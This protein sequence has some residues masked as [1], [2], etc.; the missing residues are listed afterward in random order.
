MNPSFNSFVCA[1]LQ[2]EIVIVNELLWDGY[3]RYI[4]SE[5][6]IVVPVGLNGRNTFGDSGVVDGDDDE[7]LSVL[8]RCGGFAIEGCKAPFMFT[9]ELT[10]YPNVGAIVGSSYMDKGALRVVGLKVKIALI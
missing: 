4:S 2:V 9:E 5:A 1:V 10:I 7:I 8:Q 6:S 3:Q